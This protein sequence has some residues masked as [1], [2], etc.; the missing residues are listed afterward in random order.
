[1]KMTQGAEAP[2]GNG[3]QYQSDAVGLR[4]GTAISAMDKE[5]VISFEA[6]YESML[7]CK[8]G[9]LWKASTA[10][11]FLNGIERCLQLEKELK[12]GTYEARPPKH[13]KILHPK[14]RDI[15]SIAFRDRVYQRSLNDNAI[16]PALTKGFIYDNMACQKGKGTDR[17]RGRLECF[18]QKSY[19]KNR[20]E[21]YV[22]QCDIKGYYPNM[23][24]DVAKEVFAAALDP[25]IFAMAS[26]VLDGQYSGEV[27]FNPGSQMVQ[28][29]GISVL[30]KL[31]HYIKERLRIKFYIRYMDDLILIHEDRAYLERCKEEIRARLSEIGMEFNEKK[32]RIYPITEGI[33]F[34][35][36]RFRLSETGKI[37]KQIDPKN[38]KAERK[39]LAR[40]AS[41]V[42]KGERTREKADA[43][44][45]SWRAHAEHGNSY[46][47]LKRMDEYYKNLWR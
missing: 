43:C 10:S 45:A 35:G 27:G 3:K 21:S 33:M 42:K 44:Y 5:E 12:D 19:R 38:V 18:M 30:N 28:I 20:R 39:R 13:F 15:I 4:A 40:M 24:H 11:F 32:T 41:L 7:K 1:M 47:L 29:C 36:F 25:E 6:L 17:A 31:D 46:K 23:R 34:L 22:L 26:R 37:Y 2:A 14:E 8:R 9:V 16:Y